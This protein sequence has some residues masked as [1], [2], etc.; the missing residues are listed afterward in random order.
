MT[1]GRHAQSWSGC[2][3][4]EGHYQVSWRNLHKVLQWRVLFLQLLFFFF[5]SVR[6]FQNLKKKERK[7]EKRGKKRIGITCAKYRWKGFCVL[8][9]LKRRSF[10]S[11]PGFLLPA[12]G[13]HQATA[14]H[15]DTWTKE[16][17]QPIRTWTG[18]RGHS[19]VIRKKACGGRGASWG[20]HVAYGC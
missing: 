3:A 4:T 15:L 16:T 14:L 2:F 5:A 9:I 13:V 1:G 18:Q 6:L 17:A 12:L 10:L 19:W 11:H 7:M 20:H 8:K